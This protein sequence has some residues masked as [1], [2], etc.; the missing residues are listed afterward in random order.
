MCMPLLT[1]VPLLAIISCPRYKYKYFS[2]LLVS[3]QTLFYE[4]SKQ[5]FI[6]VYAYIRT[7]QVVL[8]VRNLSA[9]AGDVRDAGSIPGLGRSPVERHG[10]PLQYSCL[11]NHMDRGAWWATVHGVAKS[12]TRLKWLSTHTHIC[13]YMYLSIYTYIGFIFMKK[14]Q[15]IYTYKICIL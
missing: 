7:F 9:N 10:N 2:W 8:V 15:I 3:L 6:H 12:W 4:Y 5:S 1:L 14:D 11:E 13:I